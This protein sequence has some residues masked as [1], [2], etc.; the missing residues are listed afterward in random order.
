MAILVLDRL[1]R[2]RK[3]CALQ[4]FATDTNTEALDVGRCGRYPLGI[5]GR[6]RSTQLNRYFVKDASGLNYVVSDELRAS[7]IFGVQN[8]FADPPFGRV[9][10]ISC[11][12]VLIYLEPEVQKRVL[13]MFHFALR[14]DGHLLLGSA[15]SNGGRDELFAPLSKKWRIYRRTG[16]TR[17]EMLALPAHAMEETTEAVVMPTRSAPALSQ[18]ANIAQKLILDRFAPA[19]VLINSSYEV[20]YFCGPSDEFLLRPRGAPTQDLLVMV[21]EGLRARMRAALREASKS[22][23][24]VDVVGARM[25]RAN[26]FMPVQ[27]TVTP[28][29]STELGRLFLVVFRHD[30]HAAAIPLAGNTDGQLVRHLEEELQA[31]RDDLQGT[32]ERFEATNESLRVSNEEVITANEE[33]RSLNEELES[34]KEEL[35]SLNEELATVNQQLEIKVRELEESNG[36]LGNLLSSSDIATI[37]LDRN[38]RIKWFAPATQRQFNFISGDVGRPVSDIASA[39]GDSALVAA[40]RAVVAGQPVSDHDFRLE[41][42]RWF[43]RRALPY[44][45]DGSQVSG[46]IVTYTDITDSRLAAQAAS[47]SQQDLSA[48]LDQAEKLRKL[49]AALVLAE[50]RER[51]ALAQDLHDGLG[52]LLAV[53]SIKAT[54]MKKHRL[55]AVVRRSLDDCVDAVDQTHRKLRAMALQLNPPLLDQLGLEAALQWMADEINRSYQLEVVVQDDGTSKPME[56]AVSAILFRAVREVLVNVARHAKVNRATV[57]THCSKDRRQL[58]LTVSDA[59]AGFDLNAERASPEGGLGLLGMRERLGYLGGQVDIRSAPG[60]GTQVTI[61]VPLLESGEKGVKKT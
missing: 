30:L 44:L 8:L 6:M 27:I 31:A 58:E 28:T 59:G 2:A 1:R 45:T 41:N 17:P 43:I 33:L 20:L 22:D 38:L 16:T 10:L 46:V 61:R 42:G 34:S 57:A 35:Q 3:R 9:D 26:A 5:A 39:I 23:L 13:N 15:E 18:A 11:R 4:I 32:I 37:C 25:K 14:K 12:N 29:S 56:P 53:I 51:R 19:S 21:R 55:S 50:Q 7:V 48:S 54:V 60:K 47:S 36:D 49:S 52:Q 24:P 40:A